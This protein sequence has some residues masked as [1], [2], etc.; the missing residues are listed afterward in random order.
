MIIHFNSFNVRGLRDNKKR[1]EIFRWIKRFHNRIGVTLLQETHTTP[2][3]EQ[4]WKSDWGAHIEFCHGTANSTGVAILFPADATYQIHDIKKDDNGRF[5]LISMTMEDYTFTIVNVY[6]STKDKP[7]KQIDQINELNLM[8][9]PY[10]DDNL[11]IAGDYNICIDP[12]LDKAGGKKEEQSEAAKALL[13][14]MELANILDVWRVANEDSKRFTRREMSRS[15]LVQSRLDYFLISAHM[16]YALDTVKIKPSIKSDH[17]LISLSFKDNDYQKRGRGFWKFNV[18]LLRDITY[19]QKVN[20][21]IE[22]SRMTYKDTRNKGLLWDLIKCEIRGLTISY[23]SHISKLNKLH[24]NNMNKELTRLEE[25]LG[26]NPPAETIQRYN[27]LKSEIEKINDIKTRGIALRAKAKYVEEGEKNT[28]YFLRLEKRNYNNKCIRSLM[29]NDDNSIHKPDDILKE[30]E[31]YYKELYTEHQLNATD[32]IKE[33]NFKTI[34]DA[35]KEMCDSKISIEECA[36]ALKQLPN[37]KSP[38]SDG[39]TTEFYK[40]FWISIK[41]LVYE[42]YCYAMDVGELSIEQRRGILTLI[43]KMNRDNRYLKNWRPISLLNCDYKILTKLLAKRLQ[44][45][46]QSIVDDDQS[47]YIKDR[48]I[49]ENIITTANVMHYMNST[50]KPGIIL[51]ADFEKAFDSIKW[52]FIIKSLKTFG[53]GDH[54]I[55]WIRILYTN[56]ISCVTNNGYASEFFPLSK[57]IR[58]GCPISALLFILAVE[59]MATMIRENTDIIGIDIMDK[60]FKISQLADDTTLF[61]KDDMSLKAVIRLL[62]DFQKM[63]GLKLN[64]EKT[65]TRRLGSSR[66]NKEKPFGLKWI[67]EPFVSLGIWFSDNELEMIKLN[68]N[69]RWKKF[70]NILNI[71]KQRDLSLKGKI[72]IVKTLALPQLQYMCAMIAIPDDFIKQVNDK[73]L[74]FIW[75]GKH[76]IKRDTLIGEIKEGGFKL[77][78]FKSIVE[79]CKIRWIQRLLDVHDKKWKIFFN[80]YFKQKDIKLF[81]IQKNNIKYVNTSELTHFCKQV[82]TAWY[83]IYCIDPNEIGSIENEPLWNNKRIIIGNK[84]VLYNTWVR[85]GINYIGDIMQK[86]GEIMEPKHIKEKYNL[87]VNLLHFYS[88]KIVIKKQWKDLMKPPT[89]ELNTRHPLIL[90][91]RQLH[92]LEQLSSKKICSA[93]VMKVFK[94]PTAKAAW[95]RHGYVINDTEWSDIYYRHFNCTRETKIQSFQYKLINRHLPCNDI[96]SKWN[97]EVSPDCLDCHNRDTIEHFLFNCPLVHAYWQNVSQWFFSIYDINIRLNVVDILFGV[98]NENDDDILDVLNFVILHGK[99]YIHRQKCMKKYISFYNFQIY[100]KHVLDIE[101]CILQSHKKID[102]Y[103]KKWEMI[104]KK[105]E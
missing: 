84:P 102:V 32:S 22:S 48:F 78:H 104:H 12:K 29:N 28:A 7:R 50:N 30:C 11:I 36:Q 88:L 68:C 70:E 38:G 91:N 93:L 34:N 33:C 101:R 55:K 8:T 63:S 26:S 94:E 99:W 3:I 77:P 58:Q 64:K 4:K 83:N 20:E 27:H 46:M 74:E 81:F 56:P 76:L 15:G 40:F 79:T 61:L 103:E 37:N 57:G 42:S 66:Q 53:F 21:C 2:E 6:L 23:S 69:E 71:W 105:I 35:D 65:L 92:P 87:N 41:D 31:S 13:N 49:G 80:Y 62:E 72:T 67:Q 95:E 9:D 24:E 86:N 96:V 18:Q 54:F 45:V 82:I 89:A 5:L 60:T 97:S 90:Y 52:S 16:L 44:T 14:Y 75:K 59:I 98:Q 10:M 43:P 39:F 25:S 1:R 100:L 73:I 85:K 51:L 19:I 17:S 47:G